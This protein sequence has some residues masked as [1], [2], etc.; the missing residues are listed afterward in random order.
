MSSWLVTKAPVRFDELLYP[1]TLRSTIERTSI[2]ANPPHLLLSGPSGVGKTA[3]WRLI[4]RQVLGS[5]WQARTHV[6][7]ARDLARTSGAMSKF[8]E[9]LRP[10]GA[11]SNDTLAGRTSLDAYDAS[12]SGVASTTP[13]PAGKE[14]NPETNNGRAPVSRLIVIED[15]D[16]LG[17]IRQSYLRR[18]MESASGSARF[19]FTS[20][21]PSRVIEA[22]RSRTQHIRLPPPSRND[23]EKRLSALVAEEGLTT[24]R[25]ILGD[26]AHIANGNLRK[27]IFVTELLG[28][29]NM[30]D[31]RKNLQSLMA[32]TSVRE[33]Q[34]VLEEALRNRIHDWRWEKQGAKNSRVLKGAMG[35]L[36]L[37]MGENNLEPEDVV[38]HFHRLLTAGR[39]QLEE[40]MLTELLVELAECDVALHKTTQGRIELER[41][42]LKVAKIGERHAQAKAS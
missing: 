15:A 40:H 29:R 20:H 10:E 24:T 25:G 39:M 17:T 4:A 41:F 28:H 22:L 2:Q 8:E 33:M 35:A 38:V 9:F 37:V 32:A 14:S 3:T 11:S 19:I 27:A 18:M 23:I 13:A 36:D 6:L 12:F 16:Y 5:S 21:T 34:H 31:D 26:I 1:D 30:L 7:Q 42:L